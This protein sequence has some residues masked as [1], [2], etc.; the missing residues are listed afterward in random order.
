[1][2]HVYE[3]KKYWNSLCQTAQKILGFIIL[4]RTN[5]PEF[6]FDGVTPL[7]H[8]PEMRWILIETQGVLVAGQQ[9]F[10]ASGITDCAASD[11]RW[12][13]RIPQ[14]IMVWLGLKPSRGRVIAGPVIY[15][16]D[17][18]ATVHLRWRKRSD[19]KFIPP[20]LMEAVYVAETAW[21]NF[22]YQIS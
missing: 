10:V 14:A 21:R 11:G 20:K 12:F 19:T 22:I 4:E 9:Q 18:I 5:T 7:L 2:A 6:G 8:G 17:E 13:N 15:W 3:Y 1:M 16:L